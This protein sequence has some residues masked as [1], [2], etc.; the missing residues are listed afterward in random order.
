VLL[1]EAIG[2]WDVSLVPALPV[3]VLVASDEQDRALVGI[4]REQ[5]SHAARPQLLHVVVPRAPD[6]VG[7]RPAE[8]RAQA[9]ECIQRPGD[10]PLVATA[11]PRV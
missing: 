8:R 7:D 4:K 10:P 11:P 2:A 1:V 6:A 9:L 5:C 3:A